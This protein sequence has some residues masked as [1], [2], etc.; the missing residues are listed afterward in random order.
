MSTDT[1]T[2]VR[3]D[4]DADGIVTLTLDDPNQSANTMNELYRESMAAA[5]ERLYAEQ[6]DITGVVITSAKKTFFAGGDL[7]L[8]V[9]T[10]KENAGDVFA[11]CESIKQAL[12]RLELFPKPVV[13]AIN[14]AALGGG[15][16]ITLATQHRILV[17]DPKIKVGLP[18]ATLGLLPG[19]GGVTRAVRKWGL[20]TALMDVLLQGTQFNP[21]TALKKGVVDELVATQEELVPAAKA[22]IKAN[23]EAALSPWDAP[24]YKMPGGSPK[25]PALAG[26]LPAF[27]ALLRKQLKGAD[28]PAPRAILSAA[29]EGALVDFDT[30]SRIESRYLANLVVNQGSKNM[31]QAFFFDLQAINSG[32]LRPQGIEPYKAKKAVVLGAGMMG[33]GIAYVL[34]KAGAEVVLKDISDE[35]A[36]KGK[37]YSEGLLD[38]AISRGKSTEEKKAELLGRITPT[39]DPAAAAGADIVIEAVFED[40]ALKAKVFAEILPHLAPDALLCSNTSTLPITDLAAGLENPEDAKRFIGL[41][42]FSPVDKM[43]LVEIIAGKETSDEALAKAYDV[44][45]QIRKTPIVVND[46]RGFYT[47]RVI[48]FMVN[49]GMAML[50]EGVAPYSI[51][52]ATTSAGYPAPVLQLSDELNLELMAKI[53]K[54]TADANPDLPVHPGQA[55]VGKMLEAGR[56]GRLR[57]AGFYDYEDGKRGSIWAGLSELFPLAEEQPPIQDI[58]DRMLFAEALET[59]KTFEEGV[60]TSAAAANIG[61]IM[62][63]GFP[64][65]TGGAAQFMTGYENKATGEIGLNAFI[66]RAEELAEKYGDR[67]QPTQWLRDLAASGKG[68]P[69]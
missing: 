36:A 20:Q 47:S 21:E 19:G 17:N 52:R 18:E 10:T 43:P 56:A 24:G 49:E 53:A 44:V 7:K 30:A 39:A 1:Q 69:A 50:A 23:P 4:R 27:P 2:A 67:F 61:S 35:A 14:G 12:R 48:G 60:I 38:K 16:E 25:S 33:A 42:F 66:A 62:G 57:G 41:H 40:P 59:A 32:S 29:V 31:I 9:Q 34:A 54:A 68:F 5:V 6:D 58:R 15:Y 37:A 64:P 13:A 26:F 11:Q 45:L 65:N 3:Y 55:V 8:M 63:I 28:Y 22:W 51:E 46:S